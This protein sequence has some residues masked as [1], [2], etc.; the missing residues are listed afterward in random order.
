VW[1]NNEGSTPGWEL[2]HGYVANG[3]RFRAQDDATNRC[4]HFDLRFDEGVTWS[5]ML[6]QWAHIA[7]V[8]D[9]S[10]AGA[11]AIRLYVNGQPQTEHPSRSSML[12]A[13][14][15]SWDNTEPLEIGKLYGQSTRGSLASFK[16]V[17]GIA[18][19]CQISEWAAD[20]T[21]VSDDDLLQTVVDV[22]EWSDNASVA[23]RFVDHSGMGNN[24][25]PTPV[26][27]N[28]EN[29][30]ELHDGEVLNI[31]HS[32]S[33]NFGHGSFTIA[34]WL[35]LFDLDNNH[36]GLVV[37]K[38][39]RVWEDNEQSTAG[40]ELG[41]GYVANGIRFRAQDDA[42]NR[43]GHF[44]LQFDE[45]VTWSSMQNQW[46]HIAVVVDRSEAGAG[47]IHLYVNGQLQTEHPS[48]SSML[49]ACAGSWDN[50]EP[51]EIGKLYGQSTRG[52]LASFKVLMGVAAS[53][54][55]SEWAAE[56]SP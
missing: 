34:G 22:M 21:P 28:S 13:C 20:S 11:G 10:E 33:L 31:P 9:R 6:H 54:Q 46:A 56:G 17:R 32:D 19:P 53:D 27:L 1:E 48:R 14:A 35:K 49:L 40:W 2:G 4:G 8:I 15:G 51:L 39:N 26:S 52:S 12:L 42:T 38:G 45:G 16:V 43:C 44:D 24:I 47:A 3:I 30:I 23:D 25:D 36:P 37:G 50:T 29:V 55:I 5:S 18:T 41:H 7:V